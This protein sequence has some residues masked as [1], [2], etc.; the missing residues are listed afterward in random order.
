MTV[1]VG[2]V[3][4]GTVYMGG[5]SA[6]VAG[7]SITVRSDEKVFNNG[8][9]LIGITSSFRMRDI[10]R[11]KFDPPKQTDKQDDLE[12]MVTDFIDAVRDAFG[13]NGFGS[14]QEKSPNSGG[15][16]M[17]GYKGK[18]YVVHSDFQVGIPTLG[19]DSVGCGSDI[20]LGAMHATTGKNPEERVNSALSAAAEFSGGV[21]APFV[22]IKSKE[23]V[24]QSKPV[25]KTVKKPVVKKA[26]SKKRK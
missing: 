17:V 9:F 6:G 22:I 3:E 26:L 14:T 11:Y 10:L 4:N 20:A 13:K 15:Q 8:S 7:L 5:D 19:Y 21:C 23:T 2:L 18:L 24:L 1:I 25:K 12:Y 16:F